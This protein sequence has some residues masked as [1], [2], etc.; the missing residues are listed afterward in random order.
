MNQYKFDFRDVFRAPRLAFSLQRMWIQLVGMTVGYAGYLV[1]T[2]VAFLTGGFGIGNTWAKFGL[3]PCLFAS[4]EVFPWYAWVIYGIGTLFLLAA[5]LIAN[6][7]VSRAVYMTQ[8]GNNFYTWREAYSFAFRKLGSVLLTPVSLLILIGFMVAGGLFV[9]LLGRIPYVGELGLSLF[10]LLWLFAGLLVFFFAIVT[11]VAI[12]LVPSIIAT[13]DE[14]AFEAVF[15]SFSVVWNQPW[16]L[17]VYELQTVVLALFSMGVFAFAVKEA[18]LIM[19][20]IFT[21]SMG[22]DFVN[23]ANNGQAMLQS[24]LL[25]GQVIIEN[26]Y[27]DFAGAV[28]FSH[29]F[30]AIPTSELPVT[31]VISSYFYALSLLFMAGW[32]VSYGLSTFTVGNTVLYIIIRKHKD[33]EN[34]LERKDKE[35]E[36]EEEESAEESEEQAGKESEQQA[37]EEKKEES[38]GEEKESTE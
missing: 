34:L 29:E 27:R 8:K 15:Q 26:L 2:Y 33:D 37:D 9:G 10:T 20:G 12:L 1:L 28:Y 4:G 13:T 16:R 38:S 35:E 23:L 5:F 3:L 19:N 17:V 18:V 7:A 21:V 24:W 11:F 6:T 32:I 31:I 14:D 36:E 25:L 22:S 30:I